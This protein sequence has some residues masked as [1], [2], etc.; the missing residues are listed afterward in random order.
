VR[1]RGVDRQAGRQT[2]ETEREVTGAL[3]LLR[4]EGEATARGRRAGRLTSVK[5]TPGNTGPV[6]LHAGVLGL[7]VHAPAKRSRCREPLGFLLSSGSI[8]CDDR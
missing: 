5:R 8:C 4:L 6:E 2:T 7:T 1:L 3:H